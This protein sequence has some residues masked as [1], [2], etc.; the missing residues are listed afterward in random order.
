GVCGR[1]GA[2]GGRAGATFT[3]STIEVGS[4]CAGQLECAF[5]E[6]L[7]RGLFD[8]RGRA[9]SY[10]PGVFARPLQQSGAVVELSPAIEEDRRMTRKRTDAN[11]V[12][13][14]HREA[15][16]LPQHAFRAWRLHLVG[17][18]LRVRGDLPHRLDRGLD[19][20]THGARDLTQP[21]RNCDHLDSIV[22]C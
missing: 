8:V 2:T 18:L 11:D 1:S 7:D 19:G 15:D 22:A 17:D 14:V 9:K 13:A 12:L 6:L 16:D 4:V 20:R 10:E 3:R 21:A 5:Q